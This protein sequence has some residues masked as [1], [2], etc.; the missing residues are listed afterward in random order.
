MTGRPGIVSRL[1]PPLE[2]KGDDRPDNA[3]E[4]WAAAP[5]I[6]EKRVAGYSYGWS[7]AGRAPP[8]WFVSQ[9]TQPTQ[10]R[11][12]TN[13]PDMGICHDRRPVT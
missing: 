4:S 2:R 13:A 8:R 6:A 11:P 1:P 9:R 7:W 5:R 12:T 3:G 10:A